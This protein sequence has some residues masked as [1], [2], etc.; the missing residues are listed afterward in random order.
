[1]NQASKKSLLFKI[2]DWFRDWWYLW[3]V[4]P[5]LVCLSCTPKVPN[6]LK[7]PTAIEAAAAAVNLTDAALAA[8]MTAANPTRVELVLVWEPRVQVIDRAFTAVKLRQDLCKVLPDLRVVST[9]IACSE[10]TKVIKAAE[11]QAKCQ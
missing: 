1:M 9:A 3:V 7:F 4:L 10:C 6:D 8:S 11:S 5:M 2:Y